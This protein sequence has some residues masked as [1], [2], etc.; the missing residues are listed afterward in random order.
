MLEVRKRLPTLDPL[1][2]FEAA[3]R[4]SSF[5][6]AAKEL[7]VTASA[8]SQQIRALETQLGVA[9][10][11]RGHRSVHLTGRGKEFQNSVSVALMHLM[12]AANEVRAGEETDRL[13]IATDTSLAAQWLMPRLAR[14]EALHPEVSLR[15]NVTDVQADLLNSDFQIAVVHG[16]GTWRGYDSE[17]LFEEEVFPVCAPDYLES[18]NG[19]FTPETLVRSELLD[20]EYEHWHWMNWAIWLTEMKLPLPDAP[21]K[22]RVNS[23]PLV[24]DAAKRGAGIALGWRYLIDNALA[25][26][27][28]VRP[29][30]G[31]LRTRYAYHIVWPFNEKQS[32][33]AASFKDWLI[34][35]RDARMSATEA[36]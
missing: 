25:D 27:S 22:L 31:S 4:H 14:F 8:V 10:F 3:A 19:K 16:E 20:L 28:L 17:M 18:S 5:A 1:I 26:G 29:V 13:E 2:A 9:L 36:A 12:N 32:P 30:E 23:Y 21:R 6:L 7:N 34:T 33:T 15:I 24:I 35:E 11:D